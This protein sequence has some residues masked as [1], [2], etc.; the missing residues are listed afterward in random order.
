MRVVGMVLAVGVAV[1]YPS[2]AKADPIR[3]Q[4]GAA[5]ITTTTTTTTTT[6]QGGPVVTAQQSG[7]ADVDDDT[8]ATFQTRSGLEQSAYFANHGTAQVFADDRSSF[9][10]TISAEGLG[11]NQQ[12][13]ITIAL[14]V[15]E[16][17]IYLGGEVCVLKVP[18]AD[19]STTPEPGTLLLIAT[20]LGGLLLYRRQMF[21]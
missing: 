17:T 10:D 18:Q 9:K 7:Q 14:R 21:A 1:L 20:G 4:A 13:H 6:D 8:D 3:V 5:P 2:T 16:D 12:T 15:G 19:A 11:V